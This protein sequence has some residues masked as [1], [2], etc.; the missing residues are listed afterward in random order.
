[1]CPAYASGP[2]GVSDHKSIQPMAARDAQVGYDQLHHFIAT[3]T[4]DA[5]PLERTLLARADEMVGGD[6]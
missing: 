2:I 3:G 5:A 1:M 4:W 6:G